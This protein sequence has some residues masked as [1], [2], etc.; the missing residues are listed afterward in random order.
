MLAAIEIC[1]AAIAVALAY[2]APNLGARR[3]ERVKHQFLQLAR[4][5]NLVVVTVGLAALAARLAVLPVLPIPQPAAHDEFSHL[6]IADTFAHSRLTNPTHPMWVH[7]E[8]FHVNQRPTYASMYFPAQGAFLAIGQVVFGHPFWGVWLSAGLMSA[9]ICWMLQGWMPAGWA[10]LGGFLA[11]V[12]LATF[13]YW[14]NTYYGGAVAALG[15]ALVLGALPRIK[16]RQRVRDALLMGL[17]LALLA[18][19]RP[20]ESLFFCL[21]IAA[22]DLLS[23]PGVAATRARMDCDLAPPFPRK[24][25]EPQDSFFALGL[26]LHDDWTH[27]AHLSSNGTLRRAD[28]RRS[29]CAR[30]AINAIRAALEMGREAVWSFFSPRGACDLPRVA[31]SACGGIS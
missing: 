23:W 31:T 24:N 26:R 29:L 1:L 18:N 28:D 3:F 6:L 15:G 20:Y 30:A 10:L 19:T 14:T 7:F 21:P 16:R 25:H 5:P 4:R 22:R 17:G 12:R 8:T 9:A 13:S 27:A 11:V 2:I